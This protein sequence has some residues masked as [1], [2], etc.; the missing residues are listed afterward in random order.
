MEEKQEEPFVS[1]WLWELLQREAEHGDNEAGC[2]SE[3]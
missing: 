3:P 1:E 2:E